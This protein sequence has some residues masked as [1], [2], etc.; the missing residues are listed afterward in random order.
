MKEN[1]LKKEE[2][3]KNIFLLRFSDQQEQAKTFLRFQEHYESPEFRGKIFSLDEF[4]DWY[5]KIKGAFSYYTDWIGFNF[6]SEILKPF[7]DGA[8]DPLS[9]QEKQVLELF[10][11]TKD[12][13]YVI[14]V[15]NIGEKDEMTYLL[16]HEIA[17]G[18]F[19][20]RPE[21]KE[22][23]QKILS[24][25]DLGE[26]KEW[27]RG[28]GGYHESVIEDECHAFGLTGTKSLTVQI[29]TKMREELEAL[30]QRFYI[31]G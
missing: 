19:Y 24:K 7:R 10:K 12:P 13:F 8:F 28:R 3:R 9:E 31:R 17:H 16:K 27:L 4:K 25:Y 15:W 21:Y 18:F 26:L 11:D 20:T 5:T 2:I 22:E 23:A 1:K 14:S 6:P 30:F 29:P